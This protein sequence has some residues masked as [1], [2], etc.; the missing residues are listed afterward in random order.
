[1][2]QHFLRREQLRLQVALNLLPQSG[3]VG[4]KQEGVNAHK[5]TLRLQFEARFRMVQV[6]NAAIGKAP[7]R[8][9]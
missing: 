1:M 9:L 8:I 7:L 6:H 5:R 2:F 3:L 4:K